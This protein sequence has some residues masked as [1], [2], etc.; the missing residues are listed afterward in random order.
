MY[1]IQRFHFNIQS[2]L[3]LRIQV[4]WD[5]IL[6]HLVNRSEHSEDIR[7]H[8][9]TPILQHSIISQK[10]WML[11]CILVETSSTL[12]STWNQMQAACSIY[13]VVILAAYLPC[14]GNIFMTQL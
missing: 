8:K 7:S 6:C 12:C 10:S 2:K 11:S 9:E 1:L 5:V 14:Q 3:F 13:A 4:F